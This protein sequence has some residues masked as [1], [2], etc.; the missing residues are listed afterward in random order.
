M[1][2]ALGILF[3]WLGAVGLVI[4]IQGYR[5]LDGSG[6]GQFSGT[7]DFLGQKVYGPISSKVAAS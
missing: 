3:L 5:N 6:P 1:E 7:W 2:M 4:A